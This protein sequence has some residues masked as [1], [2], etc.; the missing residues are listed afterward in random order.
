MHTTITF[1]NLIP[2]THVPALLE[3]VEAQM[4]SLDFLGQYESAR[5]EAD[6]E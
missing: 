3:L 5:A 4:H 2:W 6:G 1:G